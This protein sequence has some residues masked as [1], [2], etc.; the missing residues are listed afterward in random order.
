MTFRLTEGFP[1]ALYFQDSRRKLYLVILNE[2]H[3]QTPK[4]SKI[5][6]LLKFFLFLFL[7]VLS[8]FR[9]GIK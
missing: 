3:Y 2:L 5:T 4:V 1:G 8:I 9:K 6:N 7:V